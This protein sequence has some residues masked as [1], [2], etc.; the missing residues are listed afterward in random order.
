MQHLSAA[1]VTRGYEQGWLKLLLTYGLQSQMQSSK[2]GAGEMDGENEEDDLF[3]AKPAPAQ[4][5]DLEASDALDSS[6]GRQMLKCGASREFWSHCETVLS[7]ASPSCWAPVASKWCE[8]ASL[9]LG[10]TM[11]HLWKLI[12]GRAGLRS[13]A[14]AH[15]MQ[16]IADN[17]CF[18]VQ[19]AVSWTVNA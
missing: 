5:D 15:T 11:P 13:S 3:V 19:L 12:Q 18:Q 4:Q 2:P 16:L 17:C 10:S 9:Q 7:Q 6:K 8:Y 14:A 1:C